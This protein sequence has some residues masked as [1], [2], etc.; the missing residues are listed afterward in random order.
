MALE[1]N[2]V[3]NVSAS[4][5][6]GGVSAEKFG[7]TMFLTRDATLSAGGSGKVRSFARMAEIE[8]VFD[9]GTEPYAA[10][11]A[12]F[13]QN[14]RPRS[15]L[16]GR[17]S[18]VAANAVVTSG[19]GHSTVA[20][21][22]AIMDG[23]LTI[24]GV[25]V[26]GIDF[27][28]DASFAD[29]AATLEAAL[30]ANA[31]V[32]ITNATVMYMN[33]RFV[34][35]TM[36]TDS[37]GDTPVA[38]GTTGTD[39]SSI[40]AL[41]AADGASYSEASP[42][43][44]VGEALS[45][46]EDIDAGWYFLGMDKDLHGSQSI[47]DAG[48]WISTRRKSFAAASAEAAALTTAEVGTFAARL[49]ALSYPRVASTYSKSA[50]YKH[51]SIVGA[52]SSTNFERPNSIRTAMFRTLFGF[53]ADQFTSAQVAELKRKRINYYTSYSGDPIYAEGWTA[54]AGVWWD[55]Q[56]WLDWLV[57]A[58]EVDVWNTLKSQPR[59]P[60]TNAGMQL[61]N[62]KITAVLERGVR[63]GGIAP[64]TVSPDFQFDIRESTDNPDFDGVLST[65]Y[66][67]YIGA[68]SA[69]SQT[70]RDARNSPPIKVW[71]KGSG[72]VHNADI[73]LTF[74]N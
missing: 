40:L 55:V 19:A 35:D 22:E 21:I 42:A 69:Q 23:S 16:V 20:A 12:Y 9:E 39:V 48:A 10:G 36:Q 66:L 11:Q 14:P 18:D 74:E 43:E 54:K 32:L 56:F 13:A 8:D 24:G 58:I 52:L 51:M 31:S 2:D 44:T 59:V 68:L 38:A 71:L 72:A 4:V 46:F 53:S 37:L 34:I 57:N 61:L 28:A 6:A 73:S 17:W 67:V 65:G 41:T 29:V 25:L 15:L 26:G 45:A 1:I 63:N 33:G 30:Q 60:L 64:G 62:E 47:L 27:D 5:A 50:D 3:V 70:D 7:R 49:Q